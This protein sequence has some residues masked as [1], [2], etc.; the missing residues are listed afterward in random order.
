MPFKSKAQK[1]WMYANYPEMAKRWQKHT[2]D[3][4]KLPERKS[5]RKKNKKKFAEASC[6]HKK[7][8]K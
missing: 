6:R 8:N 2:K 3:E 5:V 7:H 4:S 1:R